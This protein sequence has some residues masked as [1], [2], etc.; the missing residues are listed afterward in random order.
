MAS[1]HSKVNA[2]L[3][4]LLAKRPKSLTALGIVDRFEAGS[5]LEPG[6]DRGVVLVSTAL[7]EQLLEDAILVHCLKSYESPPDRD[8]LFGGDPATGN[9]VGSLHAKIILGN[10]LGLYGPNFRDDLDRLRR[11]RNVFAHAKMP[12]SLKSQAIKGALE[13]RLLDP[14]YSTWKAR[15]KGPRGKFINFV[16]ISMIFLYTIASR[17]RRYRPRARPNRTFFYS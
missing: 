2:A 14:N 17:N 9:A 15:A 3:R 10:A 4:S 6:D 11:I 1:S 7:V 16:G 8:R 5:P 13:F 12:L